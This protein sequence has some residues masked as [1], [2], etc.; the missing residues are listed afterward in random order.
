M[1]VN[2][3]GGAGTDTNGYTYNGPSLTNVNPAR[4]PLSGGNQVT[5]TGS[6]FTGT[7]GATGVT[8]GGTDAT[9]YTVNSDTSITATVPGGSGTVN[10]V[11]NTPGGPAP[12]PTATPT[13]PRPP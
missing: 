9:A 10:V 13:C 8:F 4:G 7:T 5:L 12:T 11:V 1:V 6:G 2:A 3:P